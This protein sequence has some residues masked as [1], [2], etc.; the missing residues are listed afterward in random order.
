MKRRDIV[1]LVCVLAW[2]SVCG[3]CAGTTPTAPSSPASVTP[4]NAFI[5]KV[6][7][8]IVSGV[9]KSINAT[10]SG[11]QGLTASLPEGHFLA[12][13]RPITSQCNASGTSCSVLLNEAWSQQTNCANGG[14]VYVSATLT[15]SMY[16][17]ANFVGGTLN[18]SVRSTLS[19]C[20][21]D[22]WV[23][24]SNPSILTNG[25]IYL[26]TLHERINVTLSGG[27]LVTNAPGTPT[28]RSS[29]VFNAVLF[30][31]DD[32]TGNWANSGSVDC[33]PGGS[34]RFS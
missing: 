29:C 27:F 17:N 26:S 21:E 13:P 22:G 11:S 33:T 34:F 12:A 14:Y 8:A 5:Q 9:T 31:W 1:F 24:N 23:T 7:S 6:I 4:P 3:S 18:M 30:Q 10:V 19:Q 16:G 20:S 28:G 15:G 25:T 32:I 2:V